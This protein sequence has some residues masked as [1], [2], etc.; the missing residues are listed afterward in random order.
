MNLRLQVI[1]LA[2]LFFITACDGDSRPFSEAVEVR[3]LNL[4]SIQVRGP[5]NALSEIYLNVNQELQLGIIGIPG[6]GNSITLPANDRAWSVSDPSVASIS[7]GG[8]LRAKADGVVDVS[9]SIGG[10]DSAGFEITVA[11]STLTEI[12]PIIGMTTLERCIPQ[13]YSATGIFADGTVRALDN[14]N[15]SVSDATNAELFDTSGSL[16]RLNATAAMDQLTLIVAVPDG[17]TLE[18]PLIVADSLQSIAISPL[19]IR[20][21]IDVPQNVSALGSYIVNS[22]E[23][24][25]RLAN[26]TD[27]VDWTVVTG[28]DNL[29]VSNE[30]GTK[31]LLTGL[32]ASDSGNTNL[33]ASCGE[34][35]ERV[36]V[37]I[38][39][40]DSSTA[41]ML[42]FRIGNQS[43]SGNQVTIELD[44]NSQAIPIRVSTGSEYSQ[45][46]DVTSKVD[47]Q[48][49][50]AIST[51]QEEP[52][53]IE[54]SGTDTPV[55]QLRATGVATI[56]ATE[57]DGAKAVGTITITVR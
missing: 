23:G 45:D 39:S 38:D 26:I 19:P 50:D 1:I 24:T 11:D 34:M 4:Q 12:N 14:I 15:W 10:L 6:S 30:R 51:I 29:R 27:N 20:L 36:T 37:V 43:I 8:L 48:I 22:D 54:D 31:G 13:T 47:F 56:V 9:V 16:T 41:T 55:I 42:A 35:R 33:T 2:A 52:F 17:P 28:R 46:N 3:T 25:T 18:Q 57:V 5:A 53:I 49:R 44:A 21:D 40:S 7:A 32:K